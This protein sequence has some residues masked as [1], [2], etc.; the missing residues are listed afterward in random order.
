MSAFGRYV[1]FESDGRRLVPGDT[2]KARDIFV[3]DTRRG[4]TT[5][6]SVDSF[7]VEGN[8]DSEYAQISSNGRFVVFQSRANNLVAGDTNGRQD[9]FV[10]DLLTGATERV[11]VSSTGSEGDADSWLPQISETGRFIAFQSM[12][13]NLVA[14]DTNGTVDVFVRDRKHGTTIRVSVDSAG[15][16][17]SGSAPDISGDGHVVCFVSNSPNLVPGDTNGRAD[18]FVHDLITGE[19]TRVS[20]SSSGAQAVGGLSVTNAIS[21]DGRYV[22]FSSTATN[23]VPDDTNARIDV[24]LH[25]RVTGT[26]TRVSV[27][28]TGAESP[29]GAWYPNISDDGRYVVFKSPGS[30]LVPVDLNGPGLDIFVHDVRTGATRLVSRDS[31]GVQANNFASQPTISPDGRYVAFYS[32]ADNLVPEDQNGKVRDVFLHSISPVRDL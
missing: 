16:Q 2:N 10:H 6:V 9:I 18:T 15:N 23:L 26:T 3:R 12:A 29:D 14:G 8:A 28:S 1:S 20:V 25:D 27:S 21:G 24:F 31:H 22:V 4:I 5:R 13:S 11:S 32:S 19:T 30:N 17:A 7:G